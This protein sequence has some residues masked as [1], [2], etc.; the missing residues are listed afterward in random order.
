MQTCVFAGKFD[1]AIAAMQT[2][3]FNVMFGED[4]TMR[5]VWLAAG[6]AVS[7]LICACATIQHYE[8]A[9]QPIGQ[10]LSAGVGDV[11]L[12]VQRERD[13]TNVAGNADMW[14]RRTN[15]GYTEVRYAG[16]EADGTLIFVRKDLAIHTNESTVSRMG[17]VPVPTTSTSNISGR[18]GM[19]SVSGTATTEGT[20]YLPTPRAET[21]AIP[22]DSIPIRIAPV[23]AKVVR[24]GGYRIEVQHVDA[25]ELLYRIITK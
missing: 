17:F 2:Q 14:G 1:P 7:A 23:Q 24:V 5:R 25:A 19:T 4:G 3:T 16:S 10:V 18:V 13:L 15:E 21:M 8:T 9:R 12:Y 11:V 22:S 20:T 6:I